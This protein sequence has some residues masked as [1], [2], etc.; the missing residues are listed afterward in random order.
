MKLSAYIE[1][2]QQKLADLGDV[3]VA[4]TQSGYYA[5]GQFADFYEIPKLQ[6]LCIAGGWRWVDG[7]QVHVP[8][9]YQDF[10]ILGHSHQSY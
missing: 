6:H 5:E 2:L 1:T 3:E 9:A 7:K 4:I 8:E 10:L